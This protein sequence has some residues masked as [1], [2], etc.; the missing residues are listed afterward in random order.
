MR[1][2]VKKTGMKSRSTN[3]LMTKEAQSRDD[4]EAMIRHLIIRHS[5]GLGRSDFVVASCFIPVNLRDLPGKL[6]QLTATPLPYDTV[7]PVRIGRFHPG[8]RWT[9]WN[10]LGSLPLA[11]P[12]EQFP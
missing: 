4:E 10:C 12:V 6:D 7:N 2:Y 9:K 1:T 11:M 3:E 5:F 8:E